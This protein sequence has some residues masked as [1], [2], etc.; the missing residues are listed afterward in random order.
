MLDADPGRIAAAVKAVADVVPGHYAS[1]ERVA[2]LL[3]RLGK[4]EAAKFIE[5]K[6]PRSK[7]IRSG[8]LGEILAT[9]YVTEFTGYS[10]VFRLRWKDHRE[11]AMR[12]EDIIG[13]QIDPIKKLKFLKG[14]AKSNVSLSTGTVSKARRALRSHN[15]RPSPHAL[16]FLADRLHETGEDKLADLVDDALL[17]TGIEI[18]QLSHLM[19]TFSGND[20]RGLL[21]ADLQAYR[22]RI[23]QNAVG[24]RVRDHQ[25]FIGNVYQ[26]VIAN[27]RR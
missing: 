8:D 13:L 2:R 15:G 11:M 18:N 16:S 19:F 5:G 26:T 20:P 27:G 10:A 9:S 12:G 24:L 23:S 3:K 17:T 25:A 4:R 22:G 7:Q 14:E 1:H 6:L 21:R